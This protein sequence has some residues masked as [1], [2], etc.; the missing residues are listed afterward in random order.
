MAHDFTKFPELTNA[1]FDMLYFSSPHKQITEDF[2][3]KVERVIDGD[4][5]ELNWHERDFLF[6]IRI[7]N[8]A[9]PE[10]KEDGGEESKKYLET[11]LLGHEADII[12]NP[13]NRVD[14]WG[15]LLGYVISA[16]LDIGEMSI[17][18]GHSIPWGEKDD[19]V[20]PSIKRLFS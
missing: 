12:I 19:G 5:V 18:A 8:I 17:V 10:L 16:G 4:T 7:I 1:Q 9:A 11:H 6:P 3:A 14:K 15:R 13:D 2:R 20:I